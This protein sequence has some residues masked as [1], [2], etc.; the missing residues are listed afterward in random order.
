VN[1]QV[2][3]LA[4][5]VMVLYGLLFLQLNRVTVVSA[6]DINDHPLN[7]R[8]LQRDFG[9]PRGVIQTADGVLVARTIEVDDELERL[10]EYPEG[11]LYAHSAGFMSLEFGAAGVEKEYNDQLSGADRDIAIQSFSDL[12]LDRVRTA[13]VT[14]TLE[15]SVQAVARELLGERNGSVVALDPTSGRVLA[16]WSYPA[17]DPNGLSTHD[18]DAAADNREALLADQGQPLLAKSYRERFTPGSTFKVVT[19]SAGLASGTVTREQPVYPVVAEYVPPQTERPIRNFGG[20]ACGGNLDQVMARSCNTSFAQMAVD[21]GG[22]QMATTAE[23][24]GFNQVPPFDLDDGAA[25]LYPPAEFFEDN[26]PLL[27]QSGI[28]EFD[29]AATPLQMALTAAAVAN[30][31]VIMAPYVVQEIR[32][33]DG[34][35]VETTEPRAWRSAMSLADAQTMQPV[36]EGVVTTGTGTIMQIPGV[37]VAAKTGTAEFSA[38]HDGTHAWMIAFAPVEEPRVALAVIV[39]GDETTGPQ[40]G[41]AVA[42]PIARGVLEAALAATG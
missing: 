33:S 13:D 29:V 34:H 19:G 36:L 17:F 22:E 14:L 28:G 5:V 3:R 10:R 40:T 2:R 39:E 15:H 41:S 31:G 35:V 24:F 9:R 38:T 20:V 26:Q 7:T 1:R 12:F 32:D 37:R 42:G 27:A 11:D 6:D 16:M 30:D 21:L 4:V 18:L 25:S 23:D 8:A